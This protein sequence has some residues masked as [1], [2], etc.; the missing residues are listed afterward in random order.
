QPA[1]QCAEA[2][3]CLLRRA[4]AGTRESCEAQSLCPT[5]APPAQSPLPRAGA[6][7]LC[8]DRPSDGSR[9]V[10]RDPPLWPPGLRGGQPPAGA[11]R[12]GA[13]SL[14][15]RARERAQRSTGVHVA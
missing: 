7:A 8:P 14:A 13:T 5:R 2:L 10:S 9:A 15:Y 11:D 1:A 3:F 4:A 12:L 6:T